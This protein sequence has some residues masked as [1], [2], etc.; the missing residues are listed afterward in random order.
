M[1]RNSVRS[2]S[3]AEQKMGPKESIH[4]LK[5][6][7]GNPKGGDQTPKGDYNCALQIDEWFDH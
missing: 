7:C 4:G 5:G 1:I 3:L 6:L 2:S